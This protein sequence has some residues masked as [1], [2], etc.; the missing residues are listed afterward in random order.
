MR[1]ATIDLMDQRARTYDNRGPDPLIGQI[2]QYLRSLPWVGEAAVRVR[3]QGQVFHV[4]AFVQP[5]TGQVEVQQLDE[6][7][8]GVAEL[9]WKV[10]D[11]VVVPR[12]KLPE[13]ADPGR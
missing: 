3:D 8:A 12:A 5:R 11:V 1:T 4:E 7:S 13:Q 6:A 2:T 9:D 10:Q